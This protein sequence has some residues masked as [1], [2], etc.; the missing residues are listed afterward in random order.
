MGTTARISVILLVFGFMTG[1]ASLGADSPAGKAVAAA[2]AA[3]KKAKALANEWRDT[4]IMIKKAEAALE[5]GNAE[6]AIKQANK[7]KKQADDA[8]AQANHENK[9]YLK[10]LSKAD[11]KA[12]KRAEAAL[13]KKKKK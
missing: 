9:K 8:V 1:C 3:N 13:A 12:L 4:G 7:A 6:E 10:S 2:K 5:D 11:R